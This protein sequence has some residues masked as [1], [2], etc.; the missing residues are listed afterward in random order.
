MTDPHTSHSLLGAICDH[1]L[2]CDCLQDD[3]HVLLLDDLR[4]LHQACHEALNSG[5]HGA[6]LA[7][8]GVAY[9]HSSCDVACD[10]CCHTCGMEEVEDMVCRDRC[11]DP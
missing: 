3:L 1:E 8:H 2:R 11:S 9:D 5:Y 4:A 10:A 6:C 7:C